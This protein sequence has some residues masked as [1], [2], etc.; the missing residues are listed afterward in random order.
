MTLAA[1]EVRLNDESGLDRLLVG[2]CCCL[3]RAGPT[4]Y[5]RS[6]DKRSDAVLLQ[7]VWYLRHWNSMGLNYNLISYLPEYPGGFSWDTEASIELRGSKVLLLLL[8]DATTFWSTS[9]A[10]GDG[11]KER[12]NDR[13]SLSV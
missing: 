10:S 8:V 11:V 3:M 2:C 7:T 13:S 1:P 5:I 6:A 9:D 12:V 4:L